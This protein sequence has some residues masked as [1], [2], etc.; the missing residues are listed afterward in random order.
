MLPNPV[1]EVADVVRQPAHC[2]HDQAPSQLCRGHRGPTAFGHGDA[3]FS[4]GLEVNVAAD[5]ARLHNQ[6]EFGE[7]FD[8]GAGDVGALAD[9][10]NHISVFEPY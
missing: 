10:D 1:F 4:A 3:P 8:Q 2:G 9:E 6:L 5:P 7:F